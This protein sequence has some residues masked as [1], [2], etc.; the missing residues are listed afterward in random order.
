[1][2]I[3]INQLTVESIATPRERESAGRETRQGNL[4]V[5]TARE[6]IECDVIAACDWLTNAFAHESPP[7]T[8]V[9]GTQNRVTSGNRRDLLRQRFK[10]ARSNTD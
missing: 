4:A 2:P 5:R 8:N 1:L 7:I 3:L 6:W 9:H 10:R